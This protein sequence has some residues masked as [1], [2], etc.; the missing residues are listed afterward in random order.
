MRLQAGALLAATLLV[1]SVAPLR[2]TTIVSYS[3]TSWMSSITS[4]SAQDANF[5]TIQNVTYGPSGY[6][7]SD[8]FTITG[9]DGAGTFLQGLSFNGMPSLKGGSDAAAQIQVTTPAAGETALLFMLAS[10]PAATGYTVTL[11]DGQVFNLAST[12]TI[13]G[14]SVSHPLTYATLSASP[15]SSLIL[16]D[17]SYGNTTLALDPTGGTGGGGGTGTTDP[18]PDPSAVPE[19]TTMLLLGTGLLLIAFARKRVITA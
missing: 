6:T 8:G 14:L 17:V 18:A 19:A 10:T 7:T 9:P 1:A 3:I 16:Q 13:F 2:A 15:G 12:T 11:S 5:S 4:G